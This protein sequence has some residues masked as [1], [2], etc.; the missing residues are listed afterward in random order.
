MNLSWGAASVEF[1]LP[2][3]CAKLFMKKTPKELC[4]PQSKTFLEHLFFNLNKIF[5]VPAR[6]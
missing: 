5:E 3:G 1:L 6:F 2:I 4:Q